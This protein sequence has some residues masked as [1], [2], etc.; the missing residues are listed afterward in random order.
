MMEGRARLGWVEATGLSLVV[1]GLAG[2]LPVPSPPDEA[3]PRPVVVD[4][5]TWPVMAD[6]D[7]A[8]QPPSPPPSPS[9][10]P[11]PS[12]AAPP[13]AR[14]PPKA[15]VAGP[16]ND[17]PGAEEGVTSVVSN[18]PDDEAPDVDVP[19]VT[20]LPLTTGQLSEGGM[21]VRVGNTDAL[22]YDAPDVPVSELR[23]FRG[24]GAGGGG[25]EGVVR[26]GGTARAQGW[27][28][29]PQV[30]MAIQ[31]DYPLRARQD[32]QEG[33]VVLR[34]LV[35]ARGRPERVEVA[36]GVHPLL[37]RAAVRAARQLRFD[38]ARRGA[39]A[40]PAWTTIDFVFELE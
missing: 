5:A 35:D 13:P 22:D 25:Q 20:G 9:P 6:E 8:S 31:P 26:A 17:A 27:T 1:H 23:G 12:V 24:G 3:A 15:R 39:K 21:P 28:R 32:G 37:D 11:K 34:V 16:R 7:D 18:R 10:P 2:L 33:R 30:R 40:V 38:A 36:S 4:V 29:P 14:T 19:V